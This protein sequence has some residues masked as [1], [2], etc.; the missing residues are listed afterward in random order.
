MVRRHCVR[1]RDQLCGDAARVQRCRIHKIRDV[2]ERLPKAKAS[3]SRWVMAQALKGEADAGIQKLK[4][5][6]KHPKAQHPDAAAL[7]V[8][9]RA[10]RRVHRQVLVVGVDAIKLRVVVAEQAPQKS[11]YSASERFTPTN[12]REPHRQ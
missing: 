1:G 9:K 12:L 4:A 7:L 5:H 11:V 2:T 6:A 10:T 3:Q 8:V